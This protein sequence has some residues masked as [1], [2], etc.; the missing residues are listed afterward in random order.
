MT[1]IFEAL[2]LSSSDALILHDGGRLLDCNAA[3]L[4]LFGAQ[5]RSQLLETKVSDLHAG[6]EVDMI[7]T[8]AAGEQAGASLE[9]FRRIDGTSFLAEATTNRIDF[10]NVNVHCLSLRQTTAAKAMQRAL[11]ARE[12]N[13]RLV[14]D[15]L[16]GRMAWIGSD[17]RFRYINRSFEE[18]FGLKRDEVIGRTVPEIIGQ[19]AY[20]AVEP[21]GAAAM[22]GE[23]Q[24]WEGWLPYT[25][26]GRRYVKRTY[27]PSYRDDGEIDG[28][29]IFSLDLSE[30]KQAEQEIEK[31]REALSQSEKLNA[32]GSLLAGVAH[33]LN[34]PLSVVLTQATLLREQAREPTVERR[35]ERIYSAAERCARI[36][37]SFLAIARQKPPT[38]EPL[39]VDTLI[40]SA[41]E[42]TGYGLRANGI[43]VLLDLAPGP[44]TVLGDSDHLTQVFMNLLINAQHALQDIA[45]ERRIWITA[46]EDQDHLTI[47]IA[48]N[49]PGIAPEVASRMFEPFFTTKP[50]GLG[51]GIGL[52]V[53]RGI[54]DAHGG[55]LAAEPTPGGGATFVVR[56]PKAGGGLDEASAGQVPCAR[57]VLA[58]AILVVDDEPDIG[59][60][61]AEIIAPFAERVDVVESGRAAIDRL[62]RDHYDLIISDMRMPDLDGPALY[63]H[64]RSSGIAADCPILFVTGDT[65]HHRLGDF[66]ERAGARV[67]EKPF[68][69]QLLRDEVTALLT[70]TR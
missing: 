3:A 33:E 55:T 38:R 69:P 32:L 70:A 50:H 13:L 9:R 26:A 43:E 44:A 27:A 45:A 64:L 40:R 60:V 7:P 48:D 29:F 65:L 31:Q 6:R 51:T 58:Q 46:D 16:P 20:E 10:E 47:R 41:L 2:F 68:E 25:A 66:L 39:C 67:L 35:G 11:E 59:E 34:N 5:E 42:L 62:S 21:L 8:E 12:S 28:Y 57:R 23:I 37:R 22:R 53:C 56:L 36:V 24:H 4:R 30:Q 1:S 14:L 54:V 63:D 17:R 49:G 15:A 61:I 19:T 18:L 52:S